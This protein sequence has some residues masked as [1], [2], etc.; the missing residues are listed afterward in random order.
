MKKEIEITI[1]IS[2]STTDTEKSEKAEE[3]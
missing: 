2:S 1:P 3:V